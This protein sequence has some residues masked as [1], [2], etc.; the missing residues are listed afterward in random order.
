ML[1]HSL[2]RLSVFFYYLSFIKHRELKA[3]IERFAVQY[4][5]ENVDQATESRDRYRDISE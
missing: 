1:K 4:T 5:A 3:Y 2:T